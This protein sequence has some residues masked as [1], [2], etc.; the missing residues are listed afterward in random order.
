MSDP[1]L[2]PS[3]AQIAMMGHNITA[4]IATG[5]ARR[6]R[7][8]RAGLAATVVATGLAITA[9]AIGVATATPEAQAAAYFCYLADDLGADWAAFGPLDGG[10]PPTGNTA[11]V[12]SALESCEYGF[13]FF[14]V[15]APA[16]TAC[17]LPNLQLAVFPNLER[18]DA[19][20][21]C[22]SLGLG[23]PPLD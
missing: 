4:R 1:K 7:R 21:F 14:G 18:A 2:G 8:I 9:A 11:R 13:G 16:P 22:T 3:P 10:P 20:T 15:Q 23:L 17:E 12:A 6:R 19:T 5:A